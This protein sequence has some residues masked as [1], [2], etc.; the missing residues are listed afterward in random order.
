M[1]KAA[2]GSRGMLILGI[3]TSCDETAAAVVEKGRIVL[4]SV[5]ASQI[6]DHRPSI[7][8]NIRPVA[9][10]CVVNLL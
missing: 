5:I 4:S 2:S 7:E 3:E 9:Q 8:E 6:A 10:Q 1:R